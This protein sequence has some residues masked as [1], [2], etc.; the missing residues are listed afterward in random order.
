MAFIGAKIGDLIEIPEQERTHLVNQEEKLPE[1]PAEVR[2][3]VADVEESVSSIRSPF[4]SLFSP[5]GPAK[6]RHPSRQTFFF[7]TP[8]RDSVPIPE[9]PTYPPATFYSE[10]GLP[11]VVA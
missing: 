4:S 7:K 8:G 1:I 2:E 3:A 11:W 9:I 5:H 6:Y 10:S